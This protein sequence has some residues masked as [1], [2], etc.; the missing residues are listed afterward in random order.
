MKFKYILTVCLCLIFTQFAIAEQAEDFLNQGIQAFKQGNYTQATKF[1][2]KAC[3]DGV[4][5]SCCSLGVL[6]VEGRGVKQNYIQAIQFFEK[7]CNG[8]SAIACSNL[9][10]F[11]FKVQGR[12]KNAPIAKKYF[13]KACDLGD[14]QSCDWYKY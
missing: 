1:Y 14:Q 13:G 8:N 7:A 9:G 6:Y 4:M 12:G 2:E 5:D 10:V 11:Y 3:N